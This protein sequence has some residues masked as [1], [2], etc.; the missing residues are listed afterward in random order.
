MAEADVLERMLLIACTGD[1]KTSVSSNGANRGISG[2]TFLISP[3]EAAHACTMPSFHS[4]NPSSRAISRARSIKWVA[5]GLDDRCVRVE[6]LP[7]C[8]VATGP[9]GGAA[10]LQAEDPRRQRRRCGHSKIDRVSPQADLPWLTSPE[11]NCLIYDEDEL[12]EDPR[13]RIDRLEDPLRLPHCKET[14]VPCPNSPV[15]G[16]VSSPSPKEDARRLRD[17]AS[18]P[19]PSEDSRRLRDPASAPRATQ[20]PMSALTDQQRLQRLNDTRTSPPASTPASLTLPSPMSVL[21]ETRTL[22]HPDTGAWPLSPPRGAQSPSSGFCTL[23]A[24]KT[25]SPGSATNLAK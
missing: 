6:P 22:Q 2:G 5:S 1:P 9:D 12:M 4:S 24:A 7:E 16:Q 11:I 18:S 19:S 15:W 8:D 20:S 14:S 13:R 23:P 10:C 25:P 17:P 21:E 3:R